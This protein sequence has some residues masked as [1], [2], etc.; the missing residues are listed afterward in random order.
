MGH[1]KTCWRPR[2]P[3][4]STTTS[5]SS[6]RCSR[7]ARGT[8]LHLDVAPPLGPFIPAGSGPLRAARTPGRSRSPRRRPGSR[9]TRPGWPSCVSYVSHYNEARP[10]RGLAR[11][12]PIAKPADPARQRSSKEIRRQDVLGGLIHE[13]EIAA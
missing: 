6:A 12:T 2:S 7:A 11:Q 9:S 3:T 5:S 10:H 4:R 13:Y 1:P 8:R